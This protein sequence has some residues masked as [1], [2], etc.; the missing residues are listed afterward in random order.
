MAKSKLLQNVRE[1]IRRRGYSY[2]TE[3]SYTS[4][5]VRMIRFNKLKHPNEITPEE[6]VAYLNYL[7]N[8]RNVAPNTQ[9]Q[10]LCAIVFLYKQVL[11]TPMPELDKLQR[12][13]KPQKVPIVLSAT[14]VGVIG[15]QISTSDYRIQMAVS[16]S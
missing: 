1:E 4:W 12:A 16:V 5:I 11:K 7:A 2:R 9:N 3:Q 6:I 13:K 14:E 8:E 10:A 15:P